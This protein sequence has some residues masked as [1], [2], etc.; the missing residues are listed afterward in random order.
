VW[1]ED[2][3]GNDVTRIDPATNKTTSIKVGGAP[4]DVTFAAGAAWVTNYGDD[5]VSRIDGKT[6]KVH[7][8]KVDGSP[9]GVAPGGGAVW[10]TSKTD[11]TIDRIDP[12]TLKVTSTK[13]GN[14]ATWTSWGDG[15]LWIARGHTMTQIGLTGAER[16]HAIT[17]V[18]LGSPIP[19]DGD[20]VD[21]TL[22][23]GDNAGN[24]RGYDAASGERLG[25]W[26]LGLTQPFVLA[27]YAGKLWTVD[28]QGTALMEIDPA[29]LR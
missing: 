22:W 20:I 24:L 17:K 1:V 13:V 2:Y 26:P 18:G 23:V 3:G 15:R 19:L 16:G 28:F 6:M 5:T 4:Y 7:T 21:G 29:G 10:V 27:G 11:S 9:V 25:K 8:L 14:S 12:A